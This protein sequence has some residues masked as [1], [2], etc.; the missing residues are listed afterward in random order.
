MSGDGDYK[1]RRPLNGEVSVQKAFLNSSPN[2][3]KNLKEYLI[4]DNAFPLIDMS[5]AGFLSG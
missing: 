3:S 5:D 4:K 1:N 2:E